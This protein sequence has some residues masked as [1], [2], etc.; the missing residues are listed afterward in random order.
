M[1]TE[2]LINAISDWPVILQGVIGS[3]IFWLI[4]E[5][6][7]LVSKSLSQM[8]G[9]VSKRIEKEGLLREWLYRK[10]TSR[11]GF[12]NITQGYLITFDHVLRYLITGLLFACI[13]ILVAGI[14]KLVFSIILAATIYYLLRALAW[15]TPK[16]EWMG[17]SL[18]DHWKRVAELEKAFFGKIDEE[19]QEY[20]DKYSIEEKEKDS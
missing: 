6:P 13:A 14:G 9:F 12:I 5:L 18:S 2:T 3:A 19:T 4:L 15:L 11:N 1:D 8:L 20:L 7:K 10:F 16:K 17:D